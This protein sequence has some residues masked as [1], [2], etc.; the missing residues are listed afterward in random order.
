MN[1]LDERVAGFPDT[2][3][4]TCSFRG[5]YEI[6]S[7]LCES[8]D[9]FVPEPIKHTVYVPESDL[10]LFEPLANS[11]RSIVSEDALLPRW[12]WK[13]PL[14]SS[15]W[16]RRLLLPRRNFYLTPYSL[17]VRGWIAQ[18][19][20]KIAAAAQSSNEIVLHIDSDILFVRQLSVSELF[21]HVDRARLYR[22][23]S[24]NANSH[25]LWHL[26]AS[27]LLGLPADEF[28]DG[29]YVDSIVLWRRS[30]VHKMIERIEGVA[31]VDWQ[32]ILGRTKHFS[33]YI[34]YGVFAER[35]MGLEDAKLSIAPKSL[36][37]TRWTDAFLSVDD[38]TNFI[39]SIDP[40]MIGICIQSTIP[41]P[42]SKRRDLFD[43]AVS[44]LAASRTA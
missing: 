41:L 13:L 10:A 32:V 43:R 20:M 18:Q 27:K 7:M 25:R 5:D 1:G 33:E 17:P 21:P 23:A 15:Q 16:R 19:M 26:S 34:L 9:R 22:Q 44:F 31:K 29:E 12:F 6:C 36:C 30:V 2:S 3:M 37:H 8:I 39:N 42:M 38:E 14:P 4:I 11:R 28:H 40:R 35:V 24:A